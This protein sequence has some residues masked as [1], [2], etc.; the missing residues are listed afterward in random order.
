MAYVKREKTVSTARKTAREA[1]F[2]KAFAGA[3]R[4]VLRSKTFSQGFF[5]QKKRL[6]NDFHCSSF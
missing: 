4:P 6:L 1:S 3:K 5:P 2:S